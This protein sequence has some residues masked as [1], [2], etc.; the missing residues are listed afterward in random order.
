MTTSNSTNSFPISYK[1]GDYLVTIQENGTKT[2]ELTGNNPNHIEFPECIDVKITNYCDAGCRFC[3]EMSTEA[4]KHADL[5]ELCKQLATLPPGV[6]LAIGGGNPLSHPNLVNFLTWCKVQG[7]IPNLTINQIHATNS[8][9][10]QYIISEELAY[11]I[12]ISIHHFNW[13]ELKELSE[14]SDNVVFH[15]IAGVHSFDKVLD[16]FDKTGGQKK[17]LILGYKNFGFGKNYYG[18]KVRAGLSEWYS[19]F[20][21]L[22]TYHTVSFD[23]LALEQLNVRRLFTDKL[24]QQ[25]Y[26]GDDF[27]FTMYVDAVKQQFAPTSRS[28]NRVNW[29]DTGLLNYFRNKDANKT[30]ER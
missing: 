20:P 25:F 21:E 12:G 13:K 18:D 16:L 10:L 19:Y 23:N 7:F 3:H 11:G 26:M 8:E 1:N 4:G 28:T 2:R 9:L 24:W 14:L 15:V 29:K 6:E 17:V 27:T 22:L 5:W 30:A